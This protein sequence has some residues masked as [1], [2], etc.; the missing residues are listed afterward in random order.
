MLPKQDIHI[1]SG[2]IREGSAV[3][4]AVSHDYRGVVVGTNLG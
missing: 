3:I 4:T 2:T 1:F